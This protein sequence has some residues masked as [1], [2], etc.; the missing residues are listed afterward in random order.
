MILM[1]S[2]A[3]HTYRKNRFDVLIAGAG[4]AGS[5]AAF[6]LANN[7]Y[8]VGIIDKRRFPRPKLC[9]GLLSQKT[10]TLLRNIFNTQVSDLKANGVIHCQSNTYGVGDRS[11]KCLKGKLD[12][13]FHFVNRTLYDLQWLHQAADAG[14]K[15]FFEEKVEAVD[16]AIGKVSTR[17]GK[18]FWGRFI[19]AADGVFSRIRS[20]LSQRGLLSGRRRQDIA[21][22]LE[23]FIPREASSDF[24]DYPNIY[25]GFTPWGYAWSFPGPQNQILGI[26]TLKRKR[27]LSIAKC[28]DDFLN[29]QGVAAEHFSSVKGFALPYGNYLHK[30]GYQNVLLIGDAGGFADPFLGEGIYYAHKSAQL[31]C[32]AIKQSFNG[33]QNV[34]TL[35]NQLLNQTI[36]V[37]LKYA[38]LIRQILFSI[39][40]R[41]HFNVM[42]FMLKHMPG[43][44]AEAVQG[45]RSFKLLRPL[46]RI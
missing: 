12:F 20:L 34:L 46:N 26:C 27:R 9:G 31:A 21:A 36:I 8:R 30:A 13:P 14:A 10:I 24:A 44:L 29:T 18:Q 3:N 28:F 39:P 11:G 43:E 33:Q 38:K 41:W 22:A 5:T 15:V 45:Q 1:M 4:P 23:I 6:I 35:Y 7:G 25:Y 16:F 17:T 2:P 42:A 32:A 40:K 19:I 37:E